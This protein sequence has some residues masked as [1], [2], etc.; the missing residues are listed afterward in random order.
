MLKLKSKRGKDK[1]SLISMQ[2]IKDK[3]LFK[4]WIGSMTNSKI[5]NE[6]EDLDGSFI[7]N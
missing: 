5:P 7:E 2:K 3:S 4:S 6:A 1:P